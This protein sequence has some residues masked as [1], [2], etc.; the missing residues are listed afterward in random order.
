MITQG[1]LKLQVGQVSC[2]IVVPEEKRVQQ[3][4]LHIQSPQSKL[5]MQIP[6]VMMPNQRITVHDNSLTF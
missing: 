5:G 2:E 1:T 6:Q 4:T 3:T